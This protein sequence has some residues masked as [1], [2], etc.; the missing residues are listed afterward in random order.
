MVIS[1]SGGATAIVGGSLGQ[2]EYHEDKGY[3]V[4]TSTEQSEE[5]FYAVYLFHDVDCW[6]VGR[7]PIPGEER[8]R[9]PSFKKTPPSSGW[10]F[11][12]DDEWQDDW[13]LTVI[14]GPLTLSR[15]YKVTLTGAAAEKWPTHHR[16]YTKTQRWWFGRPVYVNT[17]GVFLYHGGSGDGW[18][19]SDT[20]GSRVLW[21]SW[22]R[23]SPAEED[24]WRYWTGSEYKSASITVTGSD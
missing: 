14:P 12:D 1:S 8:L 19:M 23:H 2:Y 4:Q 18:T 16:V 6:L 24:R 13:T 5:N 9:S 21:G 11:I 15:Q 22:A 3:Y 7:T 17:D 10:E 20:L